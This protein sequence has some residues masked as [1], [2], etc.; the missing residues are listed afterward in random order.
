M[1]SVTHLDHDHRKRENVHFLVVFRLFPNLRR[2]P[3]HAEVILARN[4]PHGIQVPSDLSET[5]IG[6][7]HMTGVFHQDVGLAGR[8]YC[9]ETRLKITTYALEATMYHITG[10][11]VGEA[12][13]NVGQLVTGLCDGQL[14]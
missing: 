9:C 12:L 14:Q 5:K 7:A 1:S 10:M 4:A 6:D 13:S 3:P 11:E 2:G 8:Q